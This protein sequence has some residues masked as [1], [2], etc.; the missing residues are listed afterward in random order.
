MKIIGYTVGTPLPKPSFDQT[1]PKKGDYIKGDRSFLNMDETL[2]ESGRPADAK[3][4]GDAINLVEEELINKADAEHEHA[5]EDLAATEA[6][7][8]KILVVVDGV[9]T[10]VMGGFNVNEDG[11]LDADGIFGGADGGSTGDASDAIRYSKQNL[12]DEQKAQARENIG[13][14]SFDEMELI[15]ISDIDAICGANITYATEEEVF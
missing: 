12:T 2:T 13:V 14:T 8:R 6:D 5:V 7:N 11:E 4:T 3:A 1:D 15:S 9:P 10:W